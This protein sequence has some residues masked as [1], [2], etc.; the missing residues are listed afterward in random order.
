VQYSTAPLVE[1]E[2]VTVC[3]LLY[4]PAPGLKVGVAA[5]LLDAGDEPLPHPAIVRVA[6]TAKPTTASRL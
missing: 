5:A 4:V 2:I 6:N 1:S 3:E